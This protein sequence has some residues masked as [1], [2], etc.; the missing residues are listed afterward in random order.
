MKY[1]KVAVTL[2]HTSQ[3]GAIVPR[4][5]VVVEDLAYRTS[6][7]LLGGPRAGTSLQLPA[8]TDI[9]CRTSNHEC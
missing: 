5:C 3:S 8:A 6:G 7:A 2:N 9:E 1:A 4:T